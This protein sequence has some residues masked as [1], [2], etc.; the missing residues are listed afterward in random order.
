MIRYRPARDVKE[1]S[2]VLQ[3]T[4]ERSQTNV[5]VQPKG[6][7]TKRTSRLP[8]LSMARLS[9]LRWMSLLH[10]YQLLFALALRQTVD[11][12]W[13]IGTSNASR[14]FPTFVRDTLSRMI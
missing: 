13:R 7:R 12:L 11:D 2:S 9:I 5:V 6:W 8:M 10:T 1:S 14:N 3:I 4:T